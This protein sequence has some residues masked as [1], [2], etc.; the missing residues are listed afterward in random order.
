MVVAWPF[1]GGALRCSASG[2]AGIAQRLAS[3]ARANPSDYGTEERE[4]S[5]SELAWPW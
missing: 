4:Q 5:T 1:H 2:E 3:I